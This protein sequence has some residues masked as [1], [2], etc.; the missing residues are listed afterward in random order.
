MD[1]SSSRSTSSSIDGGLSK[2][3]LGKT[4]GLGSFGKVKVAECVQTGLKVAIKII[5]L[6]KIKKTRGEESKVRRE[7]TI[8]QVLVHPH[9]VRLHEVIETSEN[10][11]LVMEFMES[12]DLYDYIQLKGRL[13]EDEAR[14]L[15]QQMM[16]GVQYCH[17]NMVVHRDLKPENILLDSNYDLKISDFGL[18]NVMRDGHFLRTSCGSPHYAAPE[19][20]SEQL[21]VGP[22]VDVWSCG[23]ILY[24]ILCGTLP[25]DDENT[26]AL[27]RKIKSG[28]FKF[29]RYIS[30]EARDLIAKILVVDPM[31][32]ITIPEI[33]RHQWFQA[34][35]PQYLFVPRPEPL[36]QGSRSRHTHT[37][38]TSASSSTHQSTESL[39]HQGRNWALG[40]QS[41]ADPHT[42]MVEVLSALYE[43]KVSWKKIGAYNMKCKW[44]PSFEDREGMIPNSV[45]HNNLFGGAPLVER[46]GFTRMSPNVVKFE[47]QL[48]KTADEKYVVDLQR[49][50]GPQLLFLDI[51]ANLLTQLQ[52]PYRRVHRSTMPPPLHM[53]SPAS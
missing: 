17:R 24:A 31:R 50:I 16:Y 8:M 34:H 5:D 25:F 6:L 27:Y 51:C 11:Y 14:K 12:G 48:Y 42:I 41:R 20:I 10:I 46:G 9:V 7:I 21:Y 53:Q 22:E 36:Q 28:I 32:R 29:P 23:V 30:D 49:V 44:F 47:L 33:H 19:V 3:K 45:Q 26:S 38:E 52:D 39:N 2:Y 18:S 40:F 4:I 37:S 15:F 13:P 35:P 43:L 1:A